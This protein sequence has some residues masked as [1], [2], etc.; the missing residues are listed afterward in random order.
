MVSPTLMVRKL[1]SLLVVC[2]CF[3]AQWS[4]AIPVTTA[5]DFIDLFSLVTGDIALFDI[6]LHDD[7]DFSHTKLPLPLGAHPNGGCVKYGG[8][9]HGNNHA[10]KGLV[11]NNTNKKGYKNAGLFCGFAMA[12]IENLV[13]DS[14]C[15]FAGEM[16][17]AFGVTITGSLSVINSVNKANVSGVA[18]VGGFIGS[19]TNTKKSSVSFERC[20]NEGTISGTHGMAGGFVGSILKTSK[21]LMNMKNSTNNGLVIGNVSIGGFIGMI[22]SSPQ[23]SFTLSIINSV[24]KGN[25]SATDDL[26]CGL[27]CVNGTKNEKVNTTVI[28]SM[29]KGTVDGN[30]R[31]YGITN[32]ITKA[33]NV[34]SIGEVIGSSS[35]F[36]FWAR[37]IDVDM[38]YCKQDNCR[39]DRSPV[40]LISY[41]TK[42]RFFC[43]ADN[44][45]SR[46]DTLL[47]EESERHQY[48]MMWNDELE[49]VQELGQ[50][51]EVGDDETKLEWV[52]EQII[53]FLY[54]TIHLLSQWLKTVA[55]IQPLTLL[56]MAITVQLLKFI[57]SLWEKLQKVEGK[58]VVL[59]NK[60]NS[61]F[62]SRGKTKVPK[63]TSLWK[64]FKTTI[65]LHLFTW[66]IKLF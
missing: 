42:K 37:S 12:G 18:Q 21:T 64:E 58:Y 8:T 16:A 23:Y 44:H 24:N 30:M 57:S 22:E 46:I 28:N 53:E 1:V 55:N 13:I 4:E 7:I 66:I 6:E 56:F 10:I 29:N 26:A 49:L 63:Y 40:V 51:N 59:K 54:E 17:G 35:A 43:S 32:I 48:G 19:V 34:V 31:G 14:S 41:D 38:V 11:M 27:F 61:S 47:N 52:F 2:G 5:H 3:L 65:D 15:L 25:I 9:I 62:F 39:K 50:E 60:T 20:L 33:N 45:H 36:T